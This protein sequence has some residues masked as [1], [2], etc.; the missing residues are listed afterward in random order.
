MLN[1]LAV[2]YTCQQCVSKPSPHKVSQT[3]GREKGGSY[4]RVEEKLAVCRSQEEILIR[5]EA[6]LRHC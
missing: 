4:G 1:D 6:G 5:E 2:T 3:K